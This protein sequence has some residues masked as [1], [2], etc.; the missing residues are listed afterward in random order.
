MKEMQNSK[1][2]CSKKSEC[3]TLI[4][5]VVAA[6]NHHLANQ[7]HPEPNVLI[8]NDHKKSSDTSRKR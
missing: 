5:E 1:P 6:I 3:I 7:G 2:E 4:E 8:K